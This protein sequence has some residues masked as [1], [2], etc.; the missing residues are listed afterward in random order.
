MDFS[1]LA[2][3]LSKRYHAFNRAERVIL[4]S[5]I[6]KMLRNNRKV[7]ESFQTLSDCLALAKDKRRSDTYQKIAIAS[8]NAKSPAPISSAVQPFIPGVEAQMLVRAEMGSSFERT[9]SYIS[10]VADINNTMS[11][12]LLG[13]Y[14]ILARWLPAY[15]VLI[16]IIE[17]ALRQFFINDFDAQ[18]RKPVTSQLYEASLF[19]HQYWPFIILSVVSYIGF[20]FYMRNQRPSKFRERLDSLPLFRQHHALTGATT[21]ISLALETQMSAGMNEAEVV[22]KVAVNSQPWAK[23]YLMQMYAIMQ[24]GKSSLDDCMANN[25]LF[26]NKLRSIIGTIQAVEP[27]NLGLIEAA[28]EA[29]KTSAEEISEKTA[30][31]NKY[32][33]SGVSIIMLLLMFTM[34]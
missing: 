23:T 30:R 9:L 31:I 2:G 4:Y 27:S 18:V 28:L 15:L 20:Y 29:A 34:V 32:I 12:A 7:S 3:W 11:N 24:S 14:W 8:R 19:V 10:R 25:R 21:L 26:S 22:K 33:G 16:A 5:N 17:P 13:V 1:K 6:A